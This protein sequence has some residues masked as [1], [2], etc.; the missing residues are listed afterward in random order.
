MPI[1][2]NLT[3]VRYIVIGRLIT[4]DVME[5]LT[6]RQQAVF[7]WIAGFI[8]DHNMP[9][10]VREIGRAFKIASSSVFDHLKALERKGLLKRGNL[11]PRSLEL[12]GSVQGKCRYCA[13]VPILGRIAA[14]PPSFATENVEGTL[15]ISRRLIASGKHFALRIKGDSMIDAGILD[16]DVVL[17][18]VQ[19]T[20]EDGEI[21]VCLIEGEEATLKRVY[22]EKN[23]RVRLQPENRRMKPIIVDASDLTIQG[24]VLTVERI[25]S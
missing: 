19:P 6:K 4:E 8:H 17:V 18:H 24:K 20:V 25:L 13:S 2:D 10:T 16:R 22:R 15:T 11:G 14:G 23:G 21:A 3:I 5:K 12:T 9:P 7:D 1:L